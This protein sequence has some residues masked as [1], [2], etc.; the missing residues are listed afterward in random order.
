MTL[1][2][3]AA[4]AGIGYQQCH[5]YETGAN[6]MSIGR[7]YTLAEALGVEPGHFF[8][9]L[10]AG[11]PYPAAAPAAATAGAD[12]ELRGLAPAA[13]GGALRAGPRARGSGGARRG[14]RV[15]SRGCPPVTPRLLALARTSRRSPAPAR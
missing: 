6:R 13:A 2:E 1:Q 10:G 9:G 4:A 7:L 3:L 11:E 15:A 5:K 14:R 12:A 8:Q